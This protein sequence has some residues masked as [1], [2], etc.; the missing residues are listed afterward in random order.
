MR[1]RGM[2]GGL[3]RSCVLSCMLL[4]WRIVVMGEAEVTYVFESVGVGFGVVLEEV[5]RHSLIF[6]ILGVVLHFVLFGKRRVSK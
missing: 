5:A 4:E 3:D 1:L 6:E 2:S